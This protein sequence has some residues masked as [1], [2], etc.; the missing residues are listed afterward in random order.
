VGEELLEYIIKERGDILE[1]LAS[2][3]SWLQSWVRT[4]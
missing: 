1:E 2:A 4:L 3:F